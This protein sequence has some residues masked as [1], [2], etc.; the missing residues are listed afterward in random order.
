MRSGARWARAPTH[1]FGRKL[2]EIRLYDKKLK[3]HEEFLGLYEV[4]KTEAV[5]KFK[6]IKDIFKRLV[7]LSFTKVRRRLLPW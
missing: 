7:N 3:A 1:Q 2:D 6:S 4:P 5:T